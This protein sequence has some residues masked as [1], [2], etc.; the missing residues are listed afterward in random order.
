VCKTVSNT[1]YDRSKTTE[2]IEYFNYFSIMVTKDARC[3]RQIKSRTAMT[4]ACNK[5]KNLFSVRFD[6]NLGKMFAVYICIAL[7]LGHLAKR[8][9]FLESFEIWF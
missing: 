7:N 9:R 8:S 5:E 4:K 2:N 6:L 1:D 3:T